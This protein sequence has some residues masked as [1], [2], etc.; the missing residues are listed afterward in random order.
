MTG[1]PTGRSLIR[2]AGALGLARIWAMA[3]QFAAFV[4][5][6]RFLGPEDFGI[7]ALVFLFCSFLL[8]A[9]SMGWG[10]YAFTHETERDGVVAVSLA[11]GLAGGAILAVGGGI[12]DALTGAQ[13]RIAPLCALLGLFMPLR[14]KNAMQVSRLLSTDRTLRVAGAQVFSETTFVLAI[15]ISLNLGL[16]LLSLGIARIAQEG[17]AMAICRTS[18]VCIFGH[19][20]DRARLGPMMRF[21][22]QAQLTAMAGFAQGNIST[23]L[24]GLFLGPLGTGLYRAGARFP[25]AVSE[26]I[27]EPLK[28]VAWIGLRAVRDN[29]LRMREQARSLMIAILTVGAAAFAGLSLI[30]GDL[31]FVLLGPDWRP[32]GGLI[33]LLA[34]RQF[35]LLPNTLLMA[36]LAL[37][38]RLALAPRIGFATAALSASALVVTAPFGLGWAAGGQVVTAMVDAGIVC[39]AMRRV[40]GLDPVSILRS[41]MPA[42]AGCVAMALTVIGG[43]TMLEARLPDAMDPA[44]RAICRIILSIAAGSLA[45]AAVVLVLD[46]KLRSLAS[47]V[48]LDRVRRR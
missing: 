14:A 25:G 36:V 47:Y 1:G 37:S 21:V 45:Y 22:T 13:G 43:T 20:P 8:L 39:I 16:G 28:P 35:F 15:T 29:T 10:E 42:A 33:V 17:M 27:S 7:Y 34:A 31:V 44:L 41:L 32:V 26:L 38:D 11:A 40:I 23:L 5:A 19:W 24:I 6:A 2:S 48:L 9:A 18:G 30:A 3:A 46:A 12:V 4:V